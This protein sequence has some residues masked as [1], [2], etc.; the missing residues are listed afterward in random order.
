MQISIPVRHIV[1]GHIIKY[2]LPPRWW[3]LFRI[4]LYV[5][6]RRKSHQWLESY[7]A[8]ARIFRPKS[9][10][11]VWSISQKTFILMKNTYCVHKTG[12]CTTRIA[13]FISGQVNNIVLFLLFFFFSSKAKYRVIVYYCVWK[14][15]STLD[16]SV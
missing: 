13:S 15:T 11:I 2:T 10:K 1:D 6:C 14:I 7:L 12:C 16:K 8:A 4:V 9:R 5:W 3:H